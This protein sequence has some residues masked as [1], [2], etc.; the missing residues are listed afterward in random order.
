MVVS[1]V[2]C[3]IYFKPIRPVLTSELI[4]LLTQN[5]LYVVQGQVERPLEGL[6]RAEVVRLA[7]RGSSAVRERTLDLAGWEASGEGEEVLEIGSFR[8]RYGRSSR[9][10]SSPERFQCIYWSFRAKC[11]HEGR[12]LH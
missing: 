4:D 11:R 6:S 12:G 3:F 8:P 1:V 2:Q 5:C 9:C 7:G 10:C